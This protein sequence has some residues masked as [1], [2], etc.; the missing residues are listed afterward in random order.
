MSYL[1]CQVRNTFVDIVDPVA[2]G[3]HRRVNSWAHWQTQGMVDFQEDVTALYGGAGEV[4]PY[5]G[6]VAAP[7]WWAESRVTTPTEASET[8]P[9][10]FSWDGHAG[11]A[12]KNTFLEIPTA[13]LTHRRVQSWAFAYDPAWTWPAAAQE[14]VA[15][16]PGLDKPVAADPAA[17]ARA[18]PSPECIEQFITQ[19]GLDD[20]AAEMLRSHRSGAVQ[21]EV[22]QWMKRRVANKKARQTI[23]SFSAVFVKR[24]VAADRAAVGHRRRSA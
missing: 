6:G 1:N 13:P 5:V 3:G 9:R 16:P 11:L 8:S 15:P 21:T 24:M 22:M 10:E 7:W 4:E 19:F 18:G 2:P 12:V 14:E 23:R 20:R 17:A